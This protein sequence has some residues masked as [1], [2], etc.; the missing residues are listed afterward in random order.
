MG[1][2]LVNYP[3]DCGTPTTNLLTVKLL[4]KKHSLRSKR[5]VYDH[6][7]Q[8]FLFDDT[9]EALRILQNENQPL[10]PRHH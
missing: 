9:H 3:D 10:P 7:H 5:Q 6:Q 1:E 4:L 8:R 2:N